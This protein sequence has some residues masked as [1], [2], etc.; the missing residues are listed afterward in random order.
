M[1]LEPVDL[2]LLISKYKTMNIEELR[3]KIDQW[4]EMNDYS[5][6]KLNINIAKNEL[7][8]K[9]KERKEQ[10]ELLKKTLT[11][12]S[13]IARWISSTKTV[14]KQFLTISN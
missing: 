1:R 3:A 11:S 9:D 10:I 5:H 2:E 7:E 6:Q 14:I 13:R 8:I 4:E 12:S